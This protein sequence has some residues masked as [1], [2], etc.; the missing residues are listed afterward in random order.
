[1]TRSSQTE[2]RPKVVKKAIKK[3]YMDAGIPHC[4]AVLMAAIPFMQNK[5]ELRHK[6]R[7]RRKAGLITCSN[8][9]DDL[10]AYRD[11]LYFDEETEELDVF[12]SDSFPTGRGEHIAS[13]LD[14]AKPAKL[15]GIAKEYEVVKGPREV[16][17]L[18]EEQEWETLGLPVEE[19][20]EEIYESTDSEDSCGIQE[21]P[22]YSFVLQNKR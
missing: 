17:F 12:E 10:K 15:K 14:M 21:K 3:I 6:N 2:Y 11:E 5:S 1:M 18:D 4:D 19:E 9:V 16:I 20:W 22:T 7:R 13:L 8:N